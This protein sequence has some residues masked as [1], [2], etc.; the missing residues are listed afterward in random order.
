MDQLLNLEANPH[1]AS[2]WEGEGPSGAHGT[3]LQEPQHCS[4]PSQGEARWG[5]LAAN[6][7]AVQ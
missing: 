3:I 6:Q 5:Y 4:S 1:L 2:P 7:E